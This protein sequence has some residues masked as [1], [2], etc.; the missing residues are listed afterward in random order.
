M[1]TRVFLVVICLSLASFAA[2]AQ[3]TQPDRPPW[4]DPA[5]TGINR[6]PPRAVRAVF[7]NTAGAQDA[8]PFVQSLNGDW[9][10][11][12]SPNPAARP[13]DFFGDEFDDTAWTTISVPSNMEI[14]GF[15]VPIY[16]NSTYPWLIADPPNIPANNN[17]V[18]SYRK[19]FQVPPAWRGRNVFL[20]FDG[21]SSAFFVW[22]NG[23]FIG[24]SEDSRTAAEFDI[25]PHL[26]DGSNSLAVEVYRWSDGSYLEDQDFWKLSGIFRD[27]ALVAHA[28]TFIR[29]VEVRTDLDD[30]YIDGVLRVAATI[31]RGAHAPAGETITCELFDADSASVF[32]AAPLPATSAEAGESVVR[33]QADV[34]RPRQWSAETPYLYRLMLTLRD[35]GGAE[36]EVLPLY[37]GF[38]EVELRGGR[39]LLNG[40]PIILRGVNRHEHDPVRGQAITIES[41]LEDIRL[42]K[43]HNINAVRTSHY[44]NHPAWYDLCDRLGI[45][46]IDEANIE[47]HGMGYGE[48]SLAKNTDWLAAHMDRTIRMVE[49]DKNHASV[50]IWSLGNEAG[51]GPNFTETSRWIKQRDS[52]RPTFYERAG[53]D[54]AT[55]II[56]PMYPP[57]SHLRD[58]G[59]REHRRPLIL[60]EYTHAMGNSNG[61]LDEYWNLILGSHQL[62]G[63]FVWDWVDQGI[64]MPIPPR[65]TVADRSG[66]NTDGVFHGDL[67]APGGP[68]GYVE[69]PAGDALDLRDALTIEVVYTPQPTVAQAPLLAKGDTAYAIKQLADAIELYVYAQRAGEERNGWV[70]VV[71]PLPRDWFEKARRVTGVFDGRELVLYFD[72]KRVAAA[73]L[74]GRIATNA[75]NLGIGRDTENPDRVCAARIEQVRIYSRALG[76]TK[77]AYVE[78][79]DESD[80]LVLH[81]VLADARESGEWAGPIATRGAPAPLAK[82][83]TGTTADCYWAYGGC[84]GPTGTPTDD[85]F[86]CNGLVAPDRTPHP[87]LHAISKAYQP[88][89]VRAI[90]AAKGRIEITN[91][92]DFQSLDDYVTG[93]WELFADDKQLR[94]GEIPDL[95]IPPRASK[96]IALPLPDIE[97][98]PGVE[99]FLN[100]I[101]ELRTEAEWAPAGQRIAW[102]QIE[103]PVGVP[104]RVARFADMPAIKHSRTPTQITI[105]AADVTWGIDV[106]TGLLSSCIHQE[107]ELIRD[108]LRPDFWRSPTDNDRGNHMPS[109]QGI[110]FSAHRDMHL[111]SLETRQINPQCIEVSARTTLPRISSG[112]NVLYT[113]FGN[114][115]VCVRAEFVPGAQWLPDMPRFGMRVGIDGRCSNLEWFGRGPHETYCD[116]AQAMIGRYSG[117]VSDQYVRAYSEPTESG[118]KVDVRWSALRNES[119]AGLLAIGGS[120][121][122]VNA[123]F[124]GATE[125]QLAK[126]PHEICRLDYLVWNLDLKQMGVAGD[127]SWGALPHP[128]Y[129]I[130]PKAMAYEFRLKA[131]GGATLDPM[132]ES[133]CGAPQG[134]N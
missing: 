19:T 5:V 4:L 11:H 71:A 13:V 129:R 24:F 6:L 93:R 40:R 64:R 53:D 85:N 28:P 106:A 84:F 49:R 118:N 116:R 105:H 46:V 47:S 109:R 111:E 62:Q 124:F 16:T 115:E 17:P 114:G 22:L 39:L 54:P 73:S 44:P 95:A 112:Y 122:S 76:A 58:Y 101:F 9:K 23:R 69:F 107:H 35:A 103:L 33:F 119:G 8:S 3:T 55:D 37:V 92:L 52:S 98:Q 81:A 130:Q 27:V 50:I 65:V 66:N 59:A 36:V 132:S 113:F 75:Y 125:L 108:S 14:E 77:A 117:T 18:G 82:R 96:T 120:L 57:P 83:P 80:G 68:R 104:A 94:G 70:N 100:L 10:F 134:N 79:R 26:R 20:R 41:M 110:W 42:M 29:D 88:L 30:Q 123:N 15:G 61:N 48:R 25:T 38:R 67:A 12:W 51:M 74:Y 121:L 63:A 127:D 87:G 89:R 131:L 99:Y 102:E 21:V 45:Y 7:A 133:R 91:W 86:C 78:R 126:H 1:A 90:E 97:P 2:L 60:C 32:R 72:G 128:Q 56:C 31:N 34:R 43:Q